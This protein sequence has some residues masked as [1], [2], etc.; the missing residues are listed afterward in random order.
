MSASVAKK[1]GALPADGI[2][3]SCAG[4]IG[5]GGRC[6]DCRAVYGESHRCPHCGTIA[7]VERSEVLRFRCRVCG[8]PRVPV[9]DSA[10]E[11][12][13]AERKSLTRARVAHAKSTA[14]TMGAGVLAG[15]SVLSLLVSI[16]VLS[17]AS[18]GLLPT[19]L[20]L[21]FA[22]APAAVAFL[23]WARAKRARRETLD[24]VESAYA[25][26]TREIVGQRDEEMTATELA[27]LLDIEEA[28]AELL[29]AQ[30][31]VDTFVRARVDA[32]PASRA[33]LEPADELVLSE[34]EREH[35]AVLEAE[36]DERAS[37]PKR[38]KRS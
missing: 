19:L 13:G 16:A 1:L 24:A 11:R 34:E 15:A 7:D 18:P 27:K 22:V 5:P 30:V 37:S 14:W 8:G 10:I 23:A 28:D 3:T 35:R 12:S 6:P 29:L 2:C 33:R 26:V 21:L 25:A 36:L 9:S 4:T 20:V 31:S 17:V 38:T 32:S